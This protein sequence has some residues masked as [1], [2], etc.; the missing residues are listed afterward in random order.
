MFA[1]NVYIYKETSKP[2][3]FPRFDITAFKLSE[4]VIYVKLQKQ[5]DLK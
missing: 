4:K 1:K 5:F 3:L 2:N